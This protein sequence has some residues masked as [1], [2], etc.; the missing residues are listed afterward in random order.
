[1]PN[2]QCY[3][4][5]FWKNDTDFNGDIVYA[6]DI[7]QMQKALTSYLGRKMYLADYGQGT[8]EPFEPFPLRL[9]SPG[10]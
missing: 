3:G 7:P 5:V 9:D 2:W 10:A 8:I 6:R 4:M 1:M